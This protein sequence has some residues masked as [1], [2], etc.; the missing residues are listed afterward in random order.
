MLENNFS[1][2]FVSE[3]E[4]SNSFKKKK[5]S[6]TILEKSLLENDLNNNNERIILSNLSSRIWD[7]KDFSNIINKSNGNIILN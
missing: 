4:N 7:S 3:I 5:F 2:D 1:Q 6:K